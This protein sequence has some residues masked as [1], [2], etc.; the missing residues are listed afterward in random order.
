LVVLPKIGIGVVPKIGTGST[1]K[2]WYT[3]KDTL[4]KQLFKN[5]SLLYPLSNPQASYRGES[6]EK[7][8][9]DYAKKKS[10]QN[11]FESIFTF[12]PH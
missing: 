2:N 9:E 10:S 6:K 4:L 5:N 1:T 11:G 7:R 3:T 8:G 12:E